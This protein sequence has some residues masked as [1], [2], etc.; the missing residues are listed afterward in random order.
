MHNCKVYFLTVFFTSLMTYLPASIANESFDVVI[1]NGRVIDPETGLDAIRHLGIN[2]GTIVA[3]SENELAGAQIIDASGLVVAP[4][5]IDIHS[6][7]PSLL[8]QHF[9]LLD[10]VTT[11]LDTEAGAYPVQFYGEHFLGGA[12]LNY[13]SSV[14]HFAIRIKVMEGRDQ[15]YA[16]IGRKPGNMIGDAW[17]KKA[18]TEQI[19]AMRKLIYDGLDNGGLGIGVL[20]D[21]MTN[22]VSDEELAMLFDVA[23]ERNVPLFIHVRRGVTGDSSGL[24]EVIDLAK[25]SGASLFVCHISHNAMGNIGDW[26][27]L[28]DEAN[29]QGA[30]IAT[31]TLTYGAGATTISADVF[32]RRDWQK[33]FDIT[34]S[35]VQWVST[36][37]WMTEETWHKYS[38]ER[39]NGMVNHHYMKEEWLET[40]IK[41]PGMMV[42]TDSLPTLDRQYKVNPNVAGTFS[43]L[44]GHYVR[45]RGI[46]DLTTGLAM[47]SLR[48]AQWLERASEKFKRKGRIQI[49]ADA[50][51]VIFNPDTIKDQATH[52]DPFQASTGIERVLVGGR[53]LVEGGQRIEGRY[54]GKKLSVR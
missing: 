37:E 50:D 24:I 21:Y 53:V 16:F 14:G 42:S 17:T 6:H 9:N 4:G 49:G 39:P 52:G 43:R 32:Q 51:I 15:P 26:L 10:G 31:E 38:K 12:Q 19:E 28:I 8:G 20:L 18:N 46:I 30:D 34:Y 1:E 13:G 35:D 23:A 45:E 27:T 44:L 41:W 36:G 40:A 47:T 3:I 7:S 22:A 5:F 2:K 33:I 25:S 11:Q 48:P 54:P 29:Q